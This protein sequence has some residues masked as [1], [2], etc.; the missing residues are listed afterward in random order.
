MTDIYTP[1]Q[2]KRIVYLRELRITLL[3]NQAEKRA[4]VHDN[5]RK[6]RNVQNELFILTR[7]YIYKT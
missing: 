2:V 6:L 5:S 7:N 1:E 3:R 4:E